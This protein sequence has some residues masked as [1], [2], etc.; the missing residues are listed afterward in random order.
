MSSTVKLK[1]IQDDGESAP[2]TCYACANSYMEPSG[3]A[4]LICGHKDAGVFGLYVRQEPLDHC[5]WKKFKQHPLRNRD[6]SLKKPVE[7]EGPNVE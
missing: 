6:G 5:G 7:I 1:V 2:K 4:T 3:E